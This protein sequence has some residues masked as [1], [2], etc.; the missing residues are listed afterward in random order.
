VLEMLPTEIAKTITE[1]ISIPTIGIGAG[2]YTSGQ[3]LVMQDMLGLNKEFNPKFLKKYFNGYD[4]I[5]TAL[6]EYNFEVK[7]NIF[8]SDKESYK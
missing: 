2:K 5:K 7:E 6:N 3:I 1:S 8:P 4:G